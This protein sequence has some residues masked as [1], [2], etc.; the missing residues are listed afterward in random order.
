MIIHFTQKSHQIKNFTQ[1]TKKQ[2]E[3]CKLSSSFFVE[4]DLRSFLEKIWSNL[5]QKWYFF[6]H[7][8]CFFDQKCY[9]LGQKWCLFGK[10]GLF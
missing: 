3:T 1:I 8:W 6:S 10:N 2:V 4:N 5:G 7:K 9:F